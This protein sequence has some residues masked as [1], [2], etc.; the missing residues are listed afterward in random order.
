MRHTTL[1]TGG[2]VRVTDLSFGAA[3]I[4]NLYTPV[5]PGQAR[6]AVDAAW[7]AGIRYFDTAPHYGLGLSER[8]LGEALRERPRS[9]YTLSTKVGRIL[10]PVPGTAT[11]V[12]DDLAHGFAV[13]ATHRRVWDFSADGVRRSVE[14]SL[15]RLGLDRIDIVYLHD[16]DDHAEEAF[17]QAYP[18][19]ERLR[20]E[21]TVGAIGAGMNRTEMLTRFLRDTDTDVVL[22]AGRFTLL[23]GSALTELLPEAT[24]RGRSVVV[25]GVF[26]SGLLA[27][28]RPGATYDYTAAPPDLLDR[29]LRMDAVTR[30]Y[31]VPLRAAALQYPRSHPAVASVLVGTRS[32]AEVR[33]AAALAELTLPD[34]LWAELRAEG[35]LTENG[36]PA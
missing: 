27:D 26:N 24:A 11:T 28:P 4:G 23:D 32:A 35:L 31:G 18:A 15:T 13:P 7:E 3:G 10:E 5:D 34:D 22:C 17:T 6:E 12:P 36:A 30:R 8:R 33:D 25:G 21:G 9:A 2:T 29:A 19:L 16:P 14:E 1:R 20:A